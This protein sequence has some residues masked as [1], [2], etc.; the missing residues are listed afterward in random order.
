MFILM[1]KKVDIIASDLLSQLEHSVDA[2]A[3]LISKNE[4][5]LDSI[6]SEI[7]N[8]KLI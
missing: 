6:K 3:V 2:K 7:N 5:L 1:M 8:K 4:L